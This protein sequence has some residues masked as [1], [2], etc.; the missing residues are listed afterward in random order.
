MLYYRHG[1]I[2]EGLSAGAL[3]SRENARHD[4]GLL[5][6]LVVVIIVGLQ[7]LRSSDSDISYELRPD[8]LSRLWC[9]TGVVFSAV[10]TQP[11]RLKRT[12]FRIS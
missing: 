5:A 6:R 7:R 2:L 12:L 11:S 3:W 9:L 4:E 1:I 8:E 10:C